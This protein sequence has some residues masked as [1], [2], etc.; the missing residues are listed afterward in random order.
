MSRKSDDHLPPAPV[1]ATTAPATGSAFGE[2]LRAN[3]SI[4]VAL[5][6]LW[7]INWVLHDSG[8]VD[9]YVLRI[10][11]LIGINIVLAVSLQLINGISGQFSLGH[12]GFMAVG[13]YLA[14]YPMAERSAGMTDPAN[15]VVFYVSLGVVLGVAGGV[16]FAIF[17]AMGRS[18]RLHSALPSVLLLAFAGWFLWDVARAGNVVDGPLPG[19]LVWSRSMDGLTHLFGQLNAWMTGPAA[20][21]SA[22]LPGSVQQT[23][24]FLFALIGGG[25]CA[26]VAGL[27][28]GLPTLRLRGDYLA[29][30]TL[31]F[32]E[33]IRVVIFNTPALG[34]ATGL[35]AIPS[36]SNFAWIYGAAI[37]TIVCI[38][39]L[40]RS[41]KGRNLAAVRED[42]I[43]ANA[44]GIDTTYH[45]VLAFVVGAFFAGVAGGLLGSLNSYLNP[46]QFGF[47]QSVEIVVMVTLGGLGSISGAVFT[48]A[49]L[50]LLPEV[51]RDPPSAWPWLVI[52]AVAVSAVTFAF[53][54]R[55][56][57]ITL[58]WFAAACIA[59]EAIRWLA[60][61][62]RI[63]LSDFRM[64]IYSLALIGMM[65]L[66]PQGLL[67]NRELWPPT[68]LWRR[69]RGGGGAEPRGFEVH[70]AGRPPTVEPRRET[71]AE[72]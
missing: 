50:T 71:V 31:G 38:W 68:A 25:A 45:K 47:L 67:G 49:M 11:L 65:L 36:Y 66:R 42:E 7:P 53:D 12:A 37:V 8:Q 27:V 44:V 26:A 18:G 23:L 64:I 40:A 24:C 30:A 10:I 22:A 69:L 33:I 60:D 34:G 28:V 61:R 19:Y 9:A 5:L 62:Y 20:R 51:L 56:G 58:A 16:L 46:S 57:L 54:R 43:A 17:Y 72:H 52:I 6:A 70:E 15:V 4:P 39:R 41:A 3:W 2:F 59:W 63:Q 21:L 32:A 29:I 14:A 55:R 1:T 13:A 48:A 35:T